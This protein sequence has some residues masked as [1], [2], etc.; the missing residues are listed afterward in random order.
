MKHIDAQQRQ[1]QAAAMVLSAR[2]KIER[3]VDAGRVPA[4][5][6]QICEDWENAAMEYGCAKTLKAYAQVS[7]HS[8]E[9]LH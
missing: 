6:L 2:R 7:A 5:V 1:D 4:W 9:V 8:N 3:A